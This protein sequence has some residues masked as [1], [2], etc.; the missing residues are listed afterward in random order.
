[1]KKAPHSI[2]PVADLLQVARDLR[3]KDGGCPW[4][5]EQTHA[6]LAK[7]LLEEASE[8]VEVIEQGLNPATDAAFKEELGDVLFQ[9]VIHSQ[10]AAEDGR[11]SF[12]DV[13]RFVADKL[14]ARHPHVYG[15]LQLS[16]SAQVLKN[17]EAIKARE[18][19]RTEQR[20][21]YLDGVPKILP[22]LQRAER[23]GEKAARVGFDWVDDRQLW[24]KI[25]EELR[26]FEAAENESSK[27]R[28]EEWGDLLFA[29]AQYARRQGIDAEGALRKACAKFETRFRHMER[30]AGERL[31]AGEK[32]SAEEW[33]ALWQ[34]AKQLEHQDS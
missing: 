18:R 4:D 9:V 13:A 27:R 26:E 34:S 28:E 8:L 31:S 19:E 5:L 21:S 14:I 7:H 12:A 33:D 16:D 3:D 29:L 11:F 22:A 30:L 24:E 6:S 32:L 10:L 2:D 25:R 17:W 23:L 20:A 1:M 15:E